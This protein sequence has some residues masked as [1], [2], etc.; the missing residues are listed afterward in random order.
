MNMSGKRNKTYRVRGIAGDIDRAAVIALLECSLNVSGI[1]LSSL[2]VVTRPRLA[3]VATICLTEAS[4]RLGGDDRDEWRL[5]AQPY[6]LIVDTHF[7]SFTPLYV[8]AEDEVGS[9]E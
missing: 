6:D 4:E 7:Q 8:P 2:A 1:I 5:T 9:F 3:Q